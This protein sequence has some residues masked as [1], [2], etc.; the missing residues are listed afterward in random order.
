[1]RIEKAD[2]RDTLAQSPQSPQQADQQSRQG[3]AENQHEQQQ[4]GRSRLPHGEELRLVAQGRIQ[5]GRQRDGRQRDEV[6]GL[7]G[8]RGQAG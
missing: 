4:L 3:H 2:G 6:Q 1:M 7:H 8:E 5:P